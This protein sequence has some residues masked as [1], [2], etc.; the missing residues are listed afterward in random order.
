MAIP[1]KKVEVDV[2]QMTDIIAK[3]MTQSSITDLLHRQPILTMAFTLF[4]AEI[5]STMFDIE[6]DSNG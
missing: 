2:G 1:S 4:G 6:E 5:I 3:V